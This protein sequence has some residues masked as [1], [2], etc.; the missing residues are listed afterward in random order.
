[1]L[2][3]INQD[4]FL[5]PQFAKLTSYMVGKNEWLGNMKLGLRNW[6][7]LCSSDTFSNN[8]HYTVAFN[9]LVSLEVN[10]LTVF[11]FFCN[12]RSIYTVTRFF[13]ADNF[14]DFSSL[15]VFSYKLLSDIVYNLEAE[16]V[17]MKK[18]YLCLYLLALKSI[19]SFTHWYV[20]DR[21]A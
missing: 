18:L 8:S 6:N 3:A 16:K 14:S 7:H 4:A 21:D 2:C 15:L 19:P 5:F 17:N 12:S 11:H 20:T 13:S 1:M 9:I 10:I